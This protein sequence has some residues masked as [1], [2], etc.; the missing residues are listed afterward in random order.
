MTI[1]MALLTGALALSLAAPMAARAETQAQMDANK[2][3]VLEFYRRAWEPQQIDAVK[4]FI[5]PDFIEHNPN[6]KNG[7]QGF[8]DSFG[9]RW[10]PK[11]VEAALKDPPI[12]V[13]ADG[14][15]VAL[16]FKRPR[17]DPADATKTYDSFWWDVFR[18]K[19]GKFVEH[20]DAA[21]KPNAPPPGAPPRT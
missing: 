19:N 15:I 12:I 10:K 9:P 14:D 4:D 21:L 7:L 3:L 20:W 2:K 18:I 17:R 8:I 1:K 5:A 13:N 16:V 11:P 6:A